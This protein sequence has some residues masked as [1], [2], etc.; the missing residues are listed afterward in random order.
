MERSRPRE[1]FCAMPVMLVRA[2]AAEKA[3]AQ[4]SGAVV[5]VFG[6]WGGGGVCV[7]VCVCVCVSECVCVCVCVCGGRCLCSSLLFDGWRF[8]IDRAERAAATNKSSH[9]T[10][11]LCPHKMYG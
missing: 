5:L 2:V 4:A 8:R 3:D 1:M 7:Y 9:N 6:L 11:M 10:W